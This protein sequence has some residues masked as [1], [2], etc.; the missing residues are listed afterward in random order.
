MRIAT[1]IMATLGLVTLL[2]TTALLVV[3]HDRAAA[4]LQ[5]TAAARTR[6]GAETTAAR[7]DGYLTHRLGEVAGFAAIP[8]LRAFL[9]GEAGSPA[10]LD[11]LNNLRARDGD[12]AIACGLLD[13]FG[14]C[15]LDSYSAAIDKNE[16]HHDYFRLVAAGGGPW[17]GH[18]EWVDTPMPVLVFASAVRSDSG[19]FLGM[20]RLVLES[21]RLER[22]LGRTPIDADSTIVLLD[23]RGR[24]VADVRSPEH[25]FGNARIDV[26]EADGT[27][28][29]API[30]WFPPGGSRVASGYAMTVPVGSL[31]WQVMVWHTAESYE[32]PARALVAS[33]LTHAGVVVVLLLLGGLIASRLVARPIL[34]LE[35]SARAIAEG[36]LEVVIPS[37][38]G[39]IGTLARTMELMKDRLLEAMAGLEDTAVSA[40]AAS[41]VKSQFL[42]NMSHELRTPMTAIIGYTEVVCEDEDLSPSTRDTARTIL[43][44][45]RHLLDLV[46]EILD[47]AKVEAGT[48]EVDLAEFSPSDMLEEIVELL[49]IKA[50]DK[51][52][53]LE[54]DAQ[55]LPARVRTDPYRMRQILLNLVGNAIKFT[56]TGKVTIRARM[57]KLPN[58]LV[59][60]VIDTGVGIDPQR[61]SDLF[62][63]FAQVDASMSRRHG[64]T[65]LGLAISKQIANLLG[66]D[67]TCTSELGTGSTFRLSVPAEIVTAKAPERAKAKSELSNLDGRILLVEDGKDNQRLFGHILRK[68]GAEVAIA[69]NGLAGIEQFCVDGR[70]DLGLADPRPFDLV[71]MD[72]QMPILDGYSATRRLREMGLGVPIIALTAHAMGDARNECIDAGCDECATKPI[73]GRALLEL[74]S[75]WLAKAREPGWSARMPAQRS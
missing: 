61:M 34:R 69:E 40:K 25:N 26:P 70:P 29:V 8:T 24:V 23:D 67:I 59:C 37:G 28:A 54:L 32:A 16:D 19:E 27:A 11:L 75:A 49:Q 64:G 42:A 17:S 22:V 46:N 38:S 41:Q 10:A 74:C 4:A 48:M 45:A 53:E 14:R 1:R 55:K 50:R 2:P 60:E 57:R 43:R 73:G 33:T 18:A 39:E 36:S 15:V 9:G 63:P 71:L 47:L 35:R 44:N 30:K 68:G 52:I 13:R 7:L 66:G 21:G 56:E 62:R 3:S 31:R 65:G 72:M 20:L 58:E 5:E 12:G 51:G 6:S